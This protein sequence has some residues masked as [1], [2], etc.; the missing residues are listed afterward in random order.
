MTTKRI[1]QSNKSAAAKR[2][3]GYT[4]K[5]IKVLKDTFGSNW[6]KLNKNALDAALYTMG[7]K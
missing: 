6:N 7:M 2:T 1:T 5:Q 3:W 4:D